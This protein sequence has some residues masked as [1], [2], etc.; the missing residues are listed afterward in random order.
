MEDN[1]KATK[2][3]IRS[4][5]S[6]I[7]QMESMIQALRLDS[8]EVRRRINDMSSDTHL[9]FENVSRVFK[10]ISDAMDLSLA[11]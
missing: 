11:I 10:T 8:G 1:H 3:D 5:V 2:V 4:A 6:K 9:Q 7:S